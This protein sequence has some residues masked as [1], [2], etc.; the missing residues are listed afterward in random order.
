MNNRLTLSLLP[1][2]WACNIDKGVTAFY[3]TP[4]ASITSHSDGD[5]VLEGYVLT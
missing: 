1:L 3:S 2:L 4:E 5:V